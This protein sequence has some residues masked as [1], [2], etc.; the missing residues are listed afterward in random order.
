MKDL[1]GEFDGVGGVA[2]CEWPDV[3]L[4]DFVADFA[5]D[6]RVERLAVTGCFG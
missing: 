2:A 3:V 4:E 6:V 5:Q 1:F